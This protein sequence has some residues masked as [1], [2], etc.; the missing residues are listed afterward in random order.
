MSESVRSQQTG[1][2]FYLRTFDPGLNSC[3]QTHQL[4]RMILDHH[5]DPDTGAMG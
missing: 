1:F 2:S 4:W 3:G 5:Y